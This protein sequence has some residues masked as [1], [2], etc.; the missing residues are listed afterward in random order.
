LPSVHPE[1]G[2][3]RGVDALDTRARLVSVVSLS[4]GTGNS[5]S[6]LT[7]T[8]A[9]A[10]CFALFPKLLST[11]SLRSLPGQR[12]SLPKSTFSV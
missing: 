4:S 11:W 9:S 8:M 5:D 7:G 6:P 2:D 1:A 12:P 3:H 10:F